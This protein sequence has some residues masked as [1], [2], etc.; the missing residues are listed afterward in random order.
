M[1]NKPLIIISSIITC[2]VI[3]FGIQINNV[4]LNNLAVREKQAQSAAILEAEALEKEQAIINEQTKTDTPPNNT[5]VS[6]N[7]ITEETKPKTEVVTDANG[8]QVI[9]PD[10]IVPNPNGTTPKPGTE[11]KVET[12]KVETKPTETPKVEQ[13]KTETPKAESKPT[14]NKPASKTAKDGDRRVVNGKEEVFDD[15]FGWLQV[16]GSRSEEIDMMPSGELIGH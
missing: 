14:T 10:F 7:I 15:A 12:P 9:T 4:R 11:A 8:N 1:K 5:N 6:E 13:P 3:G 16:T 2:L